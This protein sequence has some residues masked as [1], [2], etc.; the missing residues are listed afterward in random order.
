MWQLQQT[1]LEIAALQQSL[2]P[3]EAGEKYTFREKHSAW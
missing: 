1:K 2:S 3:N